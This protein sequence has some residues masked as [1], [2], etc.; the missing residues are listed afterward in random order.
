MQNFFSFLDPE[1]AHNLSIKFLST[2]GSSPFNILYKQALNHSPI[3]V[4]GIEFRNKIGLAAGLDK[5]GEAIDAFDAMGFGYVEVGTVT[6][7][8][9]PGNLKPRVYRLK[10]SRAV[11][12]RLGFNN[13]GVDNLL[14]NLKARRSLIPVGVNIG[15]NKSTPIESGK[16]DYL[17]CMEK[18]YDHA[19][20][21]SVN[22]SSPNT[23]NLRALQTGDLLNDLL[24]SLKEKQ[25]ALASS[26]G[27][28][29]PLVL[30]IAPDLI[31]DELRTISEALMQHQFDGVIATNTTVDKTSVKGEKNSEQEGGLSGAP[32]CLKSTEIIKTLHQLLGDEIPILGVGGI[33]S[34]ED[35]SEKI[36]AGAK[37]LQL[38][39]G[40]I[41]EGLPLIRGL[42]RL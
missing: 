19:S 33:S 27:K 38:Y 12:N 8:P 22:I 16:T 10:K 28:Y 13:K 30:K 31:V 6:P 42:S 36:Q 20:Y 41:Y 21:I 18:V 11:I 26:S 1:L 34:V 2:T 25:H 9:Q 4:M 3:S 5:N 35:G 32:L 17:E 37:L 7:K 39:T 15:K 29:V 24:S 14:K 40:F 23:E